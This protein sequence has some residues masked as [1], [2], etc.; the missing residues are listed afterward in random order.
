MTAVVDDFVTTTFH[1]AKHAAV[2]TRRQ[3]KGFVGELNAFLNAVRSGGK[4]PISF[5]SMARTTR[6]TFAILDSLRSGTVQPI[7]TP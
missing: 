2:K 6:V 1:G 5:A 4:P 7:E 3:D